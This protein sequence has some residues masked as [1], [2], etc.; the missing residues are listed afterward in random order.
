M[1]VTSQFSSPVG[2]ITCI[3]ATDGQLDL[4]YKIKEPT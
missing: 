3:F 1:K 2:V 4:Y